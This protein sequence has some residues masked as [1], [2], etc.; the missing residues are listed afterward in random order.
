MI[1]ALHRKPLNARAAF[2]PDTTAL[3]RAEARF[4]AHPN[5]DC[6]ERAELLLQLQMRARRLEDDDDD[7]PAED[8]AQLACALWDWM[9]RQGDV[10]SYEEYAGT[11]RIA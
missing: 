8:D 7:Y 5:S 11:A 6:P 4:S 2:A 9:E 10:V 1:A 3:M